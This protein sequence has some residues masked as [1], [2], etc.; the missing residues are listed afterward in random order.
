M[1][2]QLQ[3]V[4]N[5]CVESEV[6]KVIQANKSEFSKAVLELAKTRGVHVKPCD[7]LELCNKHFQVNVVANREAKLNTLHCS[8]V[9]G[10]KKCT[11]RVC[12]ESPVFCKRHYTKSLKPVVP[13]KVYN[14]C[15]FIKKSDGKLCDKKCE[16]THCPI[17]QRVIDAEKNKP[18]VEEK[19]EVAK[20]KAKRNEEVDRHVLTLG[21]VDYTI[22]SSTNRSIDGKVVGGKIVELSTTDVNMLKSLGHKVFGNPEGCVG[23]ISEKGGTT[24]EKKEEKE[25]KKEVKEATEKVEKEKREKVKKEKKPKDEKKDQATEEKKEEKSPTDVTNEKSDDKVKRKKAEKNKSAH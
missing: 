24:D 23:T 17:H 5:K 7:I 16:G 3:S 2:S 4:V 20:V 12:D 1:L 21:E 22:K 13:A 11:A 10:E 25:E 9:D 18:V 14:R 8:V 15:P 6:S 19:K